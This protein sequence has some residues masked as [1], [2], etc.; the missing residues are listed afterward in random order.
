MQ[1]QY[2][3]PVILNFTL[4][5]LAVLALN[6]LTNGLTN[7]LFFSVYRGSLTDPLFYFRLVGHVL[8]HADW[9]HFLGNMLPVTLGNI[10]GGLL[11]GGTAWYCYMYKKG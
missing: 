4:L 7:Q 3:S 2:N 6:F 11:V 10:V 5:S 9:D 1:L 8:G